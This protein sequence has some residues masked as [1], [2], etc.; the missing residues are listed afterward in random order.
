MND[1]VE[2]ISKVFTDTGKAVSEKTKQ[3]GEVTKLNSRIS[4]SERAITENYIAIGKYYYENYRTNPDAEVA[5]EVNAIAASIDSIVEMKAQILMLKGMVKCVKCGAECPI[6][7]VYC[8]KCGAVL[9]KPEPIV[10]EPMVEENAA[11]PEEVVVIDT[12]DTSEE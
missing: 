9:E 12:D 7:D 1:V 3:V 8:G 2:K 6:D 11:V 10:E 4:S 5:E